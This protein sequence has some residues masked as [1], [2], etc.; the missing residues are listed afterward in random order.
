MVLPAVAGPFDLGT[1][2]V[3]QALHIDP[4]TAQVDV[5]SDPL[6][7][8]LKG[9]PL[10]V[11]RIRVV[12]D[13]SHFTLNPTSCRPESVTGALASTQ[14][15]KANVA[16]P[17]K[18]VGCSRLSLKPSLTI[19]LSGA[20]RTRSGDHPTLTSVL[21]QPQHEANLLAAKV[22]LPLALALDPHNSQHVCPYKVAKKVRSGRVHCPASTIVGSA[23]A[24]TPLLSRP[25]HGK[26]YFVQ[27]IRFVHGHPIH[28]LPTLLVPLRG[29]IALDLTAETSVAGSGALVTTFPAIPDAPV[30]RF[31][32]TI[33]GGRKGV[34][35]ITGN[36]LDICRK[37]QFA[38]SALGAQNGKRRH[39]R[40]EVATPCGKT[41]AQRSGA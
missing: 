22:R 19:G 38:H 10:R 1:V 5:V 40:I 16:S 36:H 27:G 3:R 41:I 12:L 9:I 29:Q 26:V 35:V 25:L 39:Q 28:T 21:T 18:L 34:L 24:V 7:H 33:S 8:I 37:Q 31:T 14:G 23:S 20:G 11:R 6:P 17:F 32:L 4:Y 2:V 13:R 30:S 15:T